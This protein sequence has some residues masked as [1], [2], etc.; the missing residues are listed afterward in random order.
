MPTK[1][2]KP[3]QKNLTLK[4]VEKQ[5]KQLSK[6]S[7]YVI[8]PD[9]NLVVKYY[10][11]FD[12]IKIQELLQTAYEHLSYVEENNL[13]FFT[14]DEQFLQYVHYLMIMKFSSLGDDQPTDFEPQV[15][16]MNQIVSTGIFNLFYQSI[17]DGDEVMKVLERFEQFQTLVDKIVD[18]EASTREQIKSSVQNKEILNYTQPAVIH[19]LVSPAS[20]NTGLM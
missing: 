2:A 9:E 12:E 16:I 14:S 5:F 20:Q 18:L 13:T 17:F 1:Q 3:R 7:T 8:N 19:P 10:E 15:S 6:L 4:T 11:K